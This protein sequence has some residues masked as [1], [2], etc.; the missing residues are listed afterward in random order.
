MEPAGFSLREP[1]NVLNPHEPGAE[2]RIMSMH[3]KVS[4]R[5]FLNRAARR[6][7]P[8]RR[9]RRCSRGGPAEAASAMRAALGRTG[10][11]VSISPWA[12][13]AA[14]WCSRRTRRRRVGEGAGPRITYFDTGG[15]RQGRK[16][17]PRRP[18][19]ASR[20]REVFVATKVPPASR[21][22]D[23]ALREVDASLKRLQTDHVDLLHLHGLQDEAD[24]A[25]I[26][27]RTAR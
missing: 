9:C 16:R 10:V 2:E 12:A 21:T 25:K 27:A 6:R 20:R 18:V 14:S 1:G 11:S 17:D 7:A 3:E 5:E 13:G 22:R 26:E 4:R 24:L 19:L 8:S 23:A 15:L